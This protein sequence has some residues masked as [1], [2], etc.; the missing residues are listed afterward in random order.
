MS[1]KNRS[2]IIPLQGIDSE[3]P[4]RLG[5]AECGRHLPFV[6]LRLFYFFDVPEGSS[7]G[8][9]AH[10]AQE[11]FMICLAG[12]LRIVATDGAGRQT[13][14]LDDPLMGLHIPPLTW[15]DL[16]FDAPDTLACVLA[17]A[18]YV[19]ADYIRVRDEFDRII[20]AG[21]EFNPGALQPASFTRQAGRPRPLEETIE[22]PRLQPG[23]IHVAVGKSA[24]K[25]SF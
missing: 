9:H 6:P 19:E 20:S 5:V 8:G 16:T 23:G 1:D 13:F 24:F 22:P 25:V 14:D 12:R 2:R 18:K 15:V 10:H 17:S 7:R 4:G 3:K 11:Q 21:N